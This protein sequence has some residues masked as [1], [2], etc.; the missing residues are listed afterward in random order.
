MH[1]NTLKNYLKNA[2]YAQYPTNFFKRFC[3]LRLCNK[4]NT[5]KAV[6]KDTQSYMW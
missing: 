4:Y 1:A 2:Q 6:N 3:H 5:K